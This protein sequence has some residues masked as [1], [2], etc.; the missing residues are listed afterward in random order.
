[1]SEVI[2]PRAKRPPKTG[3]CFIIN[4]NDETVNVTATSV[5][6]AVIEELK[7]PE[8][9]IRELERKLSRHRR[10]S[11][12]NRDSSKQVQ[13]QTAHL[14]DYVAQ[15]E[16]KITDLEHERS[17]LKQKAT[18]PT[19]LGALQLENLQ[20]KLF[21]KSAVIGD[22]RLQLS[23]LEQEKE[24]LNK[25]FRSTKLELESLKSLQRPPN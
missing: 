22:M 19:G 21:S 12:Q 23:R 18:A 1:M 4:L 3:K 15:L 9:R 24:E 20:E 10:K 6:S 17:E 5:P 2:V 11:R 25:E 8:Q 7:S 14:S 16:G 13:D